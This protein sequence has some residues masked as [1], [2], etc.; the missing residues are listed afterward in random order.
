MDSWIGEA[1]LLALC[2]LGSGLVSSVE[3]ALLGLPKERIERAVEEKKRGA[4]GL[5]FI[6][7]NP[8]EVW[9]SLQLV[10]IF[11]LVGAG[12]SAV[13]LGDALNWR[14][15]DLLTA[16]VVAVMIWL[17]ASLLPRTL[18]K[19]DV[20]TWT[21]WTSEGVRF[22]VYLLYPVV[23]PLSVVGRSLTNALGG[24]ARPFWTPDE[25]LHLY[26]RSRSEGLGDG[27][28]DLLDSIIAFSD[29]VIREIM[30]ART[31]MVAIPVDC[32]RE[33][34]FHT[35]IEGGHSRVPVYG[36]TVDN[37]LG[38]LHVKDLVRA[39]I[40]ESGELRA[41]GNGGCEEPR[42]VPIR[43][44]L[45]PTFYVP[46]VMKI[47]ELLKEFQRRKTHMAIAVDEYGGTA[48]I[49]TLEDIIEEIV[50]E[51]QDEYD[52]EEKQLRKV[53][54]KWI[55]DGRVQV[56][57]L[58]EVFGVEFPDDASFETLAGFIMFQAG[59]LPQPGAVLDWNSLRFTVKE[60]NEKRIATV[61]IERLEI[62][63]EPPP[64][65]LK[66]APAH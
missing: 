49:V 23:W 31:E 12:V 16:S 55:A 63:S 19:R 28:E 15:S 53:G 25:L 57:D 60:A 32:S 58:E 48:G 64:K 29:T 34:I 62:E 61:E 65:G 59:Y 18:A 47:S 8:G 46:E 41:D 44:L 21:R 56:Y 1:L 3:I 38:L 6:Q 2:A 9:T 40:E 20:L 10:R 17:L 30:V 5:V 22:L 26:S 27:G 11:C 66:A 4:K 13:L 51:I 39:L 35:L 24:E 52:V 7:S 37:I 33:E 45:R 50:G 54:N 14:I 43:S 36:E 42:L